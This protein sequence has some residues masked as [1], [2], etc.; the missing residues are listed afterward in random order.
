MQE[1]CQITGRLLMQNLDVKNKSPNQIIFQII[2]SRI[3]TILFQCNLNRQILGIFENL[4]N[5]FN[6][7]ISLI[8]VSRKFIYRDKLE[9]LRNSFIRSGKLC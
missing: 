4:R 2:I 7:R 5:T 3:L 9:F 1:S 6:T 8:E